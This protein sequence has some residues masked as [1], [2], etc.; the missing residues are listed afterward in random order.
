MR[1]EN[2]LT[3]TESWRISSAD[4]RIP[5]KRTTVTGS[6]ISAQSEK[7]ATGPSQSR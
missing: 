4:M 1:P 5:R 6:P 2:S 7:R 3:F